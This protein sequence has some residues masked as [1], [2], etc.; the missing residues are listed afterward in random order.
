M[1]CIAILAACP[2]TA[3]ADG[4]PILP[5]AQV[6]AGMDC[7]GE[8]VIQGTT[9]TSF[10]VH[11][12][13]V[14]QKPS[15]GPRILV[16]V[17]GP[18]VDTTG[19]AQGFS[20]SPVL[21][22]DGTGTLRN[23]GAISEGVGVYGGKVGLVTPIEQ[24]LG[25][26]VKPAFTVKRFTGR[27]VPLLGPLTVGGLS[28]WLQSIVQQAG[29]RA[30]RLIASMPVGPYPNF[31]VQPLVPGASVGVSYAS[32]SIPIGGV[33]TVTYRD[34][35]T[36]YAFG[37]ELDGAG[38]R[39]L[40]LQDAYVYG[41]INNPDPVEGGSFKL[42]AP[43]N[44]VGVLTSDRPNGVIGE[45]GAPPGTIPVT[46]TALD[47]DTGRTLTL[48]SQ[49]ADETDLGQPTGASLIGL[50]APT[51]VAQAATQIFD[52][53]PAN[54]SGRMCFTVTIRESRAPL[55]FCNRY[56]GTGSPGDAGASP[57][58]LGGATATDAAS[59]LGLLDQVQF[60]ALHITKVAA[61][62]T[63]QRGLAQARIVTAGAPLRVKAG[64]HVTV[65]L[66]VRVYRGPLKTISFKL[67]I[68]RGARGPL[69]AKLSGTGQ[70]GSG[71]PPGGLAQAIA[72]ALGSGG[73]VTGPGPSS[74]AAL[75]RAFAATA[76]YDGLQLRYLG[77]GGPRPI[78]RDRSL[79]IMGSTRLLFL[80]HK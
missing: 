1:S 60:A 47:A 63:A 48:S 31:P 34:G 52:G 42:A 11:V 76:Q 79:L 62:I 24:M 73:P 18:A 8:T 80:V 68:P 55:Q 14:V 33:G 13:D 5:L 4:G 72:Q 6:H 39:S 58:E 19:I 2:A 71:T 77:E 15:A 36:V 10:N 20:G 78:Y 54:E 29:R 64:G 45:L 23:A 50:V 7:I 53:P 21:C 41:V 67:R 69:M 12:L 27:A 49:V 40:L 43:G 3:L 17:S 61:T 75:R 26:P 30:G 35:Q 44:T 46:V 16:S 74:I 56:V 37:H 38:R 25:E 51:A 28:P 59:A 32:G 22:D 65:R 57:P 9:I 70:A 66:K